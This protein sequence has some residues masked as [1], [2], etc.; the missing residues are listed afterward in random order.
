MYLQVLEVLAPTVVEVPYRTLVYST[1]SIAPYPRTRTRVLLKVPYRV[2]STFYEFRPQL[3]QLCHGCANRLDLTTST[4]YKNLPTLLVTL[5]RHARQRTIERSERVTSGTAHHRHCPPAL[6][7]HCRAACAAQLAQAQ[8]L[9]LRETRA[10]RRS[11]PAD[12]IAHRLI[13]TLRI[14]FGRQFPAD[15]FS[16]HGANNGNLVLAIRAAA[17]GN[18]RPAGGPA[19]RET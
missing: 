13:G 14:R 5:I 8:R 19:G 9:A 12:L 16:H 7:W 2:P 4:F 17:A 15:A 18:K 3:R 11:T 10:V 6:L 1:V